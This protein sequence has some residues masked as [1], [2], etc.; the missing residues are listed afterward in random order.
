MPPMVTVR[1]ARISDAA[2]ICRLPV[3]GFS[4][5]EFDMSDARRTALMAAARAAMLAHLQSRSLGG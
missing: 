5:L 3:Q 4:S 2:E 1:P